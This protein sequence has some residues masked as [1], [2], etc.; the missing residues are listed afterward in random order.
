[1]VVAGW[2]WQQVW[3]L[4]ESQ[5]LQPGKKEKEESEEIFIFY[6]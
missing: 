3:S 1:V 2:P 4:L 6:H 5:G